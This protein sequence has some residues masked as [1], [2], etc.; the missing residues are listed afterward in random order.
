MAYNS[1][2]EFQIQE[3]KNDLASKQKYLQKVNAELEPLEE[4]RNLADITEKHRF[5]GRIDDLSQQK[6]ELTENIGN[7]LD[8]IAKIQNELD[9]ISVEEEA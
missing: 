6:S 4:R 8:T 5:N 9:T 7:L 1:S 3:Y 2:K